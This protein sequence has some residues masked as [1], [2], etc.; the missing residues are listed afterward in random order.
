M[1][2]TSGQ[3]Q[4]VFAYHMCGQKRDGFF[5][6]IGCQDPYSISNSAWLESI[7]WSGIAIDMERRDFSSRSRTEYRV[8]DAKDV[9]FQ[10]LKPDYVSI[11]VDDDSL[12]ALE[13]VLAHGIRPTVF[14]VE[15]DFYRIGES[16][17]STQRKILSGLGYRL[18]AP[19]TFNKDGVE[20]EWEDWWVLGVQ[21]CSLWKL[22]M[23]V[24]T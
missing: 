9:S 6:D 2:P 5:I 16:L 21:P 19:L 18:V 7:G 20:L 15:H 1:T 3:G 8:C 11:D 12:A 23:V 14:T 22:M 24:P 13:N 17:R 4:D 10:L